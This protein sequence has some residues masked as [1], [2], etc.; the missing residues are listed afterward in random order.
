MGG[1]A[2][3]Q[4]SPPKKPASRPRKGLKKLQTSAGRERAVSTAPAFLV[5]AI[6]SS[7]GGLEAMTGLLRAIPAETELALV[8]V[9]HLAPDHHSIL[10]DLLSTHTSFTVVAASDELRLEPRHVYVIPP[11][12]SMTVVD[13]SLRVRQ[14]PPQAP[15]EGTVDAL[16][17]SVASEYKERAIGVILSGSANDGAAGIREIKAAGGL[18]IVQEPNEAGVDGMPRAAIA[19][20]AVDAVLPLEEI[21]RYL[22]RLSKQSFSREEAADSAPVELP[23][24]QKVF[25]LLRRASGVDFSNYKVATLRRRIERRMLMHRQTDLSE[26]VT[27]LEADTEELARLQE[28]LFI[29]V[30]SFFREPDSF[31]PCATRRFRVSWPTAF[32]RAPCAS[33]S[34]AAR[35]ARR[36]T[37]W[38]SRSSELLG[39]ERGTASPSR[40]SAPTSARRPSSRRAAGVYPAEHRRRRVA[41]APAPVLHQ[42]RRRL[43]H[44]QGGPR[45]CVFARQDVTRDPPFSKLDLVV[46]RNLLIYLSPVAAAA[47]DRRL[48]LRAADPTAS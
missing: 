14:G 4:N 38:R 9:Q 17:H 40:S 28:E 42:V 25:H 2:R 43:P 26:Y 47:G 10:P 36:S 8:L 41:R 34:P 7:A 23:L 35:P 15:H 20:G 37:R 21:G 24:L 46:C 30:T 16:F 27:K 3:S 18:T 12:A 48:S 19:T 29:H 45:R 33:G 39:D 1:R 11:D 32:P 6:G 5:A 44:Q 31:W 22:V 13:G